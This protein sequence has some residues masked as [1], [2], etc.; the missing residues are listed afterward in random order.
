M[1]EIVFEPAIPILRV[2]DIPKALE[3]Y[4]DFLGF[5]LDWQHQFA[6]DLPLYM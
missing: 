4:V 1:T 3:Y 6:P 5:A 2:Y